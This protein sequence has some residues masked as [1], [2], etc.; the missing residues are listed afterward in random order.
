MAGAMVG[1]AVLKLNVQ[2]IDLADNRVIHEST[3]DTQSSFG[4]GVFEPQHQDKLQQCLKRLGC[5]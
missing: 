2:L 5:S 4:E 1:D 3:L